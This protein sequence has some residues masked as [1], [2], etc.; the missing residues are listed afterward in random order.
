MR[1]PSLTFSIRF[2]PKIY[3]Q[4]N[5]LE[6]QIQV[7]IKQLEATQDELSQLHLQQNKVNTVQPQQAAPPHTPPTPYP[8]PPPSQ[9]S[10]AISRAITAEQIALEVTEDSLKPLLVSKH[11]LA[12]SGAP[13]HKWVY[14]HTVVAKFKGSQVAAWVYFNNLLFLLSTR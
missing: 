2:C 11:E 5:K 12:I 4:I 13:I 3:I 9:L 10:S 14:E 8:C 1:R 7:M 6:S